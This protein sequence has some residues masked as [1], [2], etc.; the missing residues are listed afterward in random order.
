MKMMMMDS[1][2][3]E[4]GQEVLLHPIQ[5][6]EVFLF[7]WVEPDIEDSPRA[8]NGLKRNQRDHSQRLQSLYVGSSRSNNSS[9]RRVVTTTPPRSS[10]RA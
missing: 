5:T 10:I 8:S 6:R 4:R 7:H 3:P 2:D 9:S 1:V